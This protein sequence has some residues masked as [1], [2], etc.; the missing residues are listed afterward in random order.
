MKKA[1][2]IQQFG[3]ELESVLRSMYVEEE[4][5]T[6]NIADFFSE[7]FEEHVAAGTV[8]LLLKQFDI[9]IRSISNGVSLA[10]NQLFKHEHVLDKRILEV[11]DGLMLSDG[12]IVASGNGHRF[13]LGTSQKEFANYCFQ[14]LEAL[15]GTEPK[16]YP[17]SKGRGNWIFHTLSHVDF[18]QQHQRWYPNGTKIIP[19][20]VSLSPMSLLLWYYGDG[21]L[22]KGKTGNSCTLRLSTDSFDRESIEMIAKRLDLELGIRSKITAERRL[23]LKTESIPTFISYIGRKPELTCYAYKFDVDDWRFWTPMKKASKVIGVSY[24]RL[25]H[26]VTLEAIDFNRSPGGKK[27]LFSDGQIE[28]LKSLHANGLLTS[29]ARSYK[30]SV[31]RGKFH[32]KPLDVTS[33]LKTIRGQGFPY[34]QLSDEQIASETANLLNVPVIPINGR[35]F[36]ASYRNNDLAINFH[37]H[38]YAVSCADK[39]SPIDVFNDDAIMSDIV[40]KSSKKME[41]LE[42][43]T[44]RRRICTHSTAKRTSVFPVRVAKTLIAR[45]GCPDMNLLDP[46]AGYS[47]RLIGLLTQ[48]N[49]GNYTGIEPCQPTVN[50]LRKSFDQLSL[51]TNEAH[52]CEIIHGCAEEILPDLQEDHFDLVFTSPPYFNLEMYDKGNPT[53]S[54]VKFSEYQTWLDCFLLRLI[55]ESKRVMKPDGTFLLGIGNPR[56]HNLIADVDACVRKIFRV[57]DVLTMHSP[58]SW[59]A[60]LAEPIFV[61]KKD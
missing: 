32:K 52:A 51:L 1:E 8:W 38:L 36:D 4:M 53:Q 54:Y 59:S 41:S 61:L 37:P 3:D 12:S 24:S 40:Q 25:A 27:V 21:T 9:P 14:R 45:Y 11:L 48:H 20:D 34:V 2:V 10:T 5:S 46:C 16:F 60:S 39:L 42:G 29:D 35:D 17:S 57:E 49:N 23:R 6:T 43:R 7:H 19:H 15:C 30:S 47:S 55:E 50:G 22:V 31:A 56:E 58:S 33:I 18:T 44:L 26:L 13:S 28:K